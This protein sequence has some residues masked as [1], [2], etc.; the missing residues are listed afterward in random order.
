ME[1]RLTRNKFDA[2]MR[3]VDRPKLVSP[4]DLVWLVRCQQQGAT[5]SDGGICFRADLAISPRWEGGADDGA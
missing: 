5:L 3:R 1:A 2:S 4:G